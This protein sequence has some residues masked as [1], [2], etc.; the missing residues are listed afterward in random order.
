MG[1]FCSGQP[2]FALDA[3]LVAA[4]RP[5][6]EGDTMIWLVWR[7]WPWAALAVSRP[8]MS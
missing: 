3:H 6:A 8:E 5:V 4:V 1:H 2:G 7:R